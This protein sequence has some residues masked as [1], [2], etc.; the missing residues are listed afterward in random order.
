MT[1]ESIDQKSGDP[2]IQGGDDGRADRQDA[3]LGTSENAD[4]A[5]TANQGVEHDRR[6]DPKGDGSPIVGYA[7]SHVEMTSSP[8]P[9][10]KELAGY[11]HVL[12]GAADRI[13]SM[14]EDSLHSEIDYQKQ[15]VEIYREDRRAEN[16]VYKFT[17]AVF[18]LMP[19]A[20][21][22]SSV[23]FFALGMNPAALIGFAGSIALLLPQ[24]IDAIKGRR[25]FKSDNSEKDK[26]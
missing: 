14:A 3:P 20:A 24:I 9:S 15:L 1:D 21:F 5:R 19:A 26:P 7:M 12:P 18:S 25:T 17:S 2:G 23:V 10:S 8:L 11:E 22:T 13:L 6:R 16:W 4:I